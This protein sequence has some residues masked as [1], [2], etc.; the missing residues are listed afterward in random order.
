MKFINCNSCILLCILAISVHAF[1][2][3]SL[4][5]LVSKRNSFQFLKKRQRQ[6]V[7]FLSDHEKSP[8]L[9]SRRNLWN[10][11]GA[12]LLGIPA[13]VEVYS[14][15]SSLTIGPD[16]DGVFIM[17][18][19]SQGWDGIK[20]STVV[21]HGAGGQDENTDALRKA[22]Q[23]TD[24]KYSFSTI[25]DWSNYST[26]L[27]QAS[28][29]GQTIG[30]FIAD[31]LVSKAPLIER[32]HV[33]GISVGAFGC[34]TC[35]ERI[36]LLCP[37]IYVQQTL[38]DPFCQRGIFD[39]GY[40]ERSF[41]ASADY[42]QQYVNTDDP[43]PSTNSPLTKCVVYDVT[44]LRPREVFGHDWPLIY[45]TRQAKVGFVAIKDKGQRGS[46]KRIDQ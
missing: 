2:P 24:N 5:L 33:I 26:N 3:S 22:L 8:A 32:V 31:Q 17:D 11:V 18:A 34:T 43:V 41:G 36:K 40:G 35:V 7:R 38:L 25:I 20:T 16:D 30:R 21:F 28:F 12:A 37:K 6:F 23:K 19:P 10:Y 29:N 14:R 39:V 9:F 13:I 44:S 1:P 42:A 45:Y 4:K 15:V 27:F 46:V